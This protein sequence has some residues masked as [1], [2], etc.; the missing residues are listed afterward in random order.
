MDLWFRRKKFKDCSAVSLVSHHIAKER[1]LNYINYLT[2]EYCLAQ[3]CLS[4]LIISLIID[5]IICY[6][7][8]FAPKKNIRN[9]SFNNETLF[10]CYIGGRVKYASE[11]WGAH[12]GNN[13]EKL[14]L[15]FVNKVVL[16]GVPVICL[17]ML[18]WAKSQWL[19][20][21]YIH[22]LE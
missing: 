2:C 21:D 4:L 14:H 22:V 11:I 17:Y 12:K 1:F 18:N 16:K 7:I 6:V 5:N 20:P 15:E 19:I 8:L 9:M 10:Y 13:I 3:L